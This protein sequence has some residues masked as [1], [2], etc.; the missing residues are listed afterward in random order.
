[1]FPQVTGAVTRDALRRFGISRR[2]LSDSK[3]IEKMLRAMA[4]Y[5]DDKGDPGISQGFWKTKPGRKIPADKRNSI[6]VRIHVIFL[7]LQKLEEI[8]TGSEPKNVIGIWQDAI[9]R[10]FVDF[11][12]GEI[13]LAKDKKLISW[14]SDWDWAPNKQQENQEV[15]CMVCT[16]QEGWID[17]KTGRESF[18][19]CPDCLGRW[20]LPC[21]KR[22]FDTACA[23]PLSMPPRCCRTLIPLHI[24]W[25]LMSAGEQDDFREKFEESKTYHR[26]YCP[27]PTCSAFL[28]DRLFTSRS[29]VSAEIDSPTIQEPTEL[30]PQHICCPKCHVSICSSCRQ[31]AHPTSTTCQ[32]REDVDEGFAEM[33]RNWGYKRCPKCNHGVRRMYGCAHMQCV[34]GAQFCW[35]CLKP[36]DICYSRGCEVEYSESIAD[37]D[38]EEQ[39]EGEEEEEG[40]EPITQAHI[41]QTPG[42]DSSDE[43]T[44]TQIAASE[45]PT[46]QTPQLPQPQPTSNS[47]PPLEHTQDNPPVIRRRNLDA[48]PGRWLA[49]N[50]NFGSE[51]NLNVQDAVW[52]CNNHHIFIPLIGD[53]FTGLPPPRTAEL[54]PITA[55]STNTSALSAAATTE[56]TSSPSKT[57]D[58]LQV[59]AIPSQEPSPRQTSHLQSHRTLQ[60]YRCWTPLRSFS[61]SEY[62]LFYV[63]NAIFRLNYR[64]AEAAAVAKTTDAA[65]RKSKW[66]ESCM[67]LLPTKSTTSRGHCEEAV[68]GNEENGEDK[69]EEVKELRL[70]Q[71]LVELRDV[72]YQCWQC[73]DV[74]CWDCKEEVGNLAGDA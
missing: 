38:E 33:L 67:K 59:A 65:K 50:C 53:R 28:S 48:G 11:L 20:C 43:T 69:E 46:I 17:K 31:I 64:V 15:H 24:V 8:D 26:T 10:G 63:L 23:S 6:L 51:P 29:K 71:E 36:Y 16:N 30:H 56:S 42:T 41:Q 57:P 21:V 61:D 55:P 19:Q 13:A 52:T 49:S 35:T 40:E 70:E 18:Y 12:R 66:R 3:Y 73:R 4:S 32:P 34:C 25:D 14:L 68:Q 47:V 22:R 54:P 39:E 62:E 1:M 7:H 45:P 58:V 72:A 9:N 74:V 44:D 60:C 5:D 37:E 27:V 2:M